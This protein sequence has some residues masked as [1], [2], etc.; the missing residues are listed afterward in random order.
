LSCE[1][2][3]T[4]ALASKLREVPRLPLVLDDAAVLTGRRR[5]VETDDLDRVARP[6]RPRPP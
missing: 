2:L 1:L 4:E 5:L 6:G 3:A